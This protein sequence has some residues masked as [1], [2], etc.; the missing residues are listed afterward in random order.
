VE[1]VLEI[2]LLGE[3]LSEDLEEVPLE[4]GEQVV[5]GKFYSSVFLVKEAKA[6]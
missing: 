3:D 5:A 6:S 1:E 2:F 4:E